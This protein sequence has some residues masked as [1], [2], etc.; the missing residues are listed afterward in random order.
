M[1]SMNVEI[2]HQGVIKDNISRYKVPSILA[3]LHVSFTIT[4]LQKL[5]LIREGC[6]AISGDSF[7]RPLSIARDGD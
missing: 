6:P 3:I 4:S 2:S 5:H 1:L 7:G